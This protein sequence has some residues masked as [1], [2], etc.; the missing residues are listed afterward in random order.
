M[1]A[2]DYDVDDAPYPIIRS[3]FSDVQE[4]NSVRIDDLR[5][6]IW[7][8]AL[9]SIADG[10][11]TV[12]LNK[13]VV[14]CSLTDLSNEYLAHILPL[15]LPVLMKKDNETTFIDQAKV[16]LSKS[17]PEV[18]FQTIG[19]ITSEVHFKYISTGSRLPK[20]IEYPIV[21]IGFPEPPE[22]PKLVEDFGNF[23]YN[24][25]FPL[26]TYT[27][28][29]KK[30]G[31][32]ERRN[33]DFLLQTS[34]TRTNLIQRYKDSSVALQKKQKTLEILNEKISSA[35]NANRLKVPNLDN[36][37]DTIE[38]IDTAI[39][40]LVETT[41]KLSD[42]LDTKAKGVQMTRREEL[43]LLQTLQQQV[44]DSKSQLEIL[45]EQANH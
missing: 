14:Y 17:L 45:K 24:R 28:L 37:S 19:A 34:K 43:E 2:D 10:R 16:L 33:R 7:T 35:T 4:S 38:Q 12:Y 13:Q 31:K 5:D 25:D 6:F 29:V 22:D 36:I 23:I 42:E 15:K 9:Q 41:D 3:V 20:N 40:A 26:T 18:S 44:R 30:R 8:I 32:L 11:V 27:D 39:T 21:C 1:S